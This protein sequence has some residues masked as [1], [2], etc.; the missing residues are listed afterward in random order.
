MYRSLYFKII[1]L[2]AVFMIT[3]MAVV[4]T[5][6]LNSV[7]RFY[8]R[9][10][11]TQ[12]ENALSPD[13][14]LCGDLAGSIGDTESQ[15]TMLSAYSTTIGIDVYRNF[16]I[17][18]MNGNFI[19]GSNEELGRLLVKTPNMIA[20]MGGGVGSAQL[21]GSDYSDY[22]V[23]LGDDGGRC[24][25]YIK[26]TQEEMRSLSWQL[27]SLILQSIFFGLCIAVILSF[28]L[29]RA[30]TS[31]IR[32]LTRGAQLITA[33]EFTHEIDV[34][35][36][37][38]IGV[39]TDTFNRMKQ[40]LKN[41]L[42]E[43]SGERRKLET[44]LSYLKDGVIAFSENGSV[45]QINKSAIQLFRKNYNESF[46]LERMLGLLCIEYAA[47]YL[48][49][50]KHNKSIILREIVYDDKALD[51][52]VSPLKYIEDNAA[53][54]GC[55]AVIHDVTGRYELDKARRE[56]VANVSHEL[57]TPL[58]VIKGSAETILMYPDMDDASRQDFLN[59]VIEESDRML[60]IIGDLLT[61]SRL[62][63]NKT[64]WKIA[65]FNIVGCTSHICDI[66]QNDAAA[67]GHTLTYRADS[68]AS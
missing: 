49:E 65:P 18:D 11:E 21:A 60:R 46:T 58:T 53:H 5:V 22:A 41:N 3:V 26:D 43:I 64:K 62:D 10:F 9:E 30:I 6:L 63:N 12:M 33:G 34:R 25:I 15:K 1:L 36:T 13:S 56:F 68:R 51:I 24:I 2:F 59:N 42:D 32:S 14:P 50:L 48:G 35:A 37:D 17:L 57:R 8:T 66:L 54:S 23:S 55:I 16:Y 7:F 31:P 4:G 19:D 45:I 61:L 28:F 27:F 47:G 40:T 52:S 20:A 39:L 38:E 44:V 29:A 67:H